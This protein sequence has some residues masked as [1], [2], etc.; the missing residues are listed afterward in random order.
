MKTKGIINDNLLVGT[1]MGFALTFENFCFS[2]ENTG[3]LLKDLSVSTLVN[4]EN[5]SHL[6]HLNIRGETSGVEVRPR[7]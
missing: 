7:T 1:N 2:L 5:L 3:C 4:H 6:S